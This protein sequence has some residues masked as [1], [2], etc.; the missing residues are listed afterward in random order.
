MARSDETWHRLRDWTAGSAQ[1]ERLAGQILHAEG[2]TDVDPSHPL[3]G[4]DGLKDAVANRESKRWVA[5]AYFPVGQKTFSKTKKKFIADHVGVAA[6]DAEAFTFVTNQSLT[7]GQRLELDDAVEGDVEIYHLERIVGILDRPGN[8]LIRKQFLGIDLGAEA[9]AAE[10]LLDAQKRLEGLQTGG[11]TFCYLMLYNFDVG[12]NIARE[13]VVIR[14]GDFP[15]YDVRLRIRDM[16]AGGDVHSENWGEISAP[17]EFRDVEWPL[18]DSVYY[19][20]FFHARNG[21]WHQDLALKKSVEEGFWK[22][23]T[24][25]LGTDGSTEVLVKDEFSD[26]QK[27]QW[28]S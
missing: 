11:D 4:K 24:R 28:R 12:L 16:D 6:N 15:L 21:Q 18:R 8:A 3:G 2:F 1:A 17:A 20:I 9:V 5:A 25:V 27:V 13:F 19:R 7:L 22:A 23:A 10:Q 14:E 26:D